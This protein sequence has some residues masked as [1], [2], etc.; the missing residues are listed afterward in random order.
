MTP[1]RTPAQN[2]ALQVFE[3]AVVHGDGC[4]YPSLVTVFAGDLDDLDA[5]FS[6][7]EGGRAVIVVREDGRQLL[8][9]ITRRPGLRGLIDRASGRVW[10]HTATRGGSL[11]AADDRTVVHR[12]RP[13]ELRRLVHAQV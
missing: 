1:S 12:S 5:I 9:E 7:L 10:L 13:A 2:A 4:G 11:P 6:P 8:L 3:E